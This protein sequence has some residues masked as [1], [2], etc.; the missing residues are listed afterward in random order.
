MTE[1][2]DG[3][4][5][6]GPDGKARSHAEHTAWLRD[7]A[8]AWDRVTTPG[9]DG[10]KKA[11]ATRA[12]ADRLDQSC[13]VCDLYSRNKKVIRS[14]AIGPMPRPMPEGMGDEM[15]KVTVTYED[16][17]TEDIFSFYPD[18][19]RYV[20]ADFIGKTRQQAQELRFRRE[21]EALW[22]R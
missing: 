13:D 2:I 8:D 16:G 17:T 4:P 9:G 6:Y 3:A 12:H 5:H 10:R 18:E 15:P 11:A 7:R 14:A 21:K 20:P 1:K 19:V 22:G